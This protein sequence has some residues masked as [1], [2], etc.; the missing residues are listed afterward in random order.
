M[1]KYIQTIILACFVVTFGFSQDP[2]FTNPLVNPAPTT[3]TPNGTTIC[4][5]FFNNDAN[6]IP[7]TTAINAVVLTISTDQLSFDMNAVVNAPLVPWFDWT[8]SCVNNCNDP[9]LVTYTIQ[10]VQNQVIPGKPNPLTDIGGPVCITGTASPTENS[11]P[12]SGVGFNANIAA[13]ASRDIDNS[14]TSNDQSVYTYTATLPIKLV[15]FNAKAIEKTSML[16]WISAQADNFSHFEVER[17]SDLKNF[18]KIGEVQYDYIDNRSAER[19]FA[20]IDE[21]PESGVNYYRLKLVDL[22]QSFEYSSI[23][24]VSF[25]HYVATLFPNPVVKGA[26]VRVFAP[27]DSGTVLIVDAHGKLSRRVQY[28]DP[29]FNISTGDM[30]A[31]VYYLRYMEREEVMKFIVIE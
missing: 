20:F 17:S 28:Q 9:Q 14:T 15:E 8:I 4:V 30:P 16:K 18:V 19:P 5:S 24:S 13:T 29:S 2:T 7:Y 26:N 11:T 3:T 6:P 25:D 23:E 21:H 31:G 12:T 27:N 1:K 10:G 22:D